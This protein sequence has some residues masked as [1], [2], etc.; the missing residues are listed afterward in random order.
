[1][2]DMMSRRQTFT[3]KRLQSKSDRRLLLLKTEREKISNFQCRRKD[4][5][6]SD[7]LIFE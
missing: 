3:F 6:F 4:T 1:M 5:K 2:V 7:E